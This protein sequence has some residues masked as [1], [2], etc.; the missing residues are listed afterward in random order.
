MES[1]IDCNNNR[2]FCLF[3]INFIVLISSYF[4]L[5][6]TKTPLH[7]K[8]ESLN[9][10]E[11]FIRLTSRI[12]AIIFVLSSV[13]CVHLL[14]VYNSVKK[15]FVRGPLILGYQVAIGV[16]FLAVSIYFLR[17][18]DPSKVIKDHRK[19]DDA[20][21]IVDNWFNSM[22]LCLCVGIMILLINAVD[23]YYCF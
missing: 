5:T 20:T 17:N 15:C 19:K 7:F 10:Q 9:K 8:R 12:I 16:S 2:V 14:I 3:L 22:V 1:L 4:A 23:F 11:K 18:Y 6:A 21:I 13:Y